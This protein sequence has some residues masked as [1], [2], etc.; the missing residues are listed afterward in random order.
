MK[1]ITGMRRVGKSSILQS[2]LH[3][4]V[5]WGWYREDQIWNMNK[6][7]PEFFHIRTGDDLW[8]ILEPWIISQWGRY[9]IA[10]DEVQEI[11]WWEQVLSG[12]LAQY[13]DRCDILITGSN[14]HLLSGELATLIAG[15]Y[16]TF[17]IYPLTWSEYCIFAGQSQ[18][19]ESF[20]DYMEF[21]GLP[22][23]HAFWKD[24]QLIISYLRSVYESI[25][26][27]DIVER[28]QIR[29]FDFL[30][31]LYYYTAGN[32]GNIVSAQSIARYLRNQRLTTSIDSI[33]QYLSYGLHT[34][35]FEK[36]GSVDPNTKKIFEIYNKYYFGDTWLR[37]AIVW[38]NP[39][40]DKGSLL[41]NII[42]MQ[43]CTYGYTV[44]IGRIGDWEIDFIAIK[45]EKKYYFQVAQSLISPE[46]REREIRSLE[47]ITDHHPKY[48]IHFDEENWGTT[49]SGIIL[50]SILDFEEQLRTFE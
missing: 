18:N 42:Y 40:R 10:I 30:K 23:I 17:R 12:I 24:K 5:L 38:Y 33:I 35:I 19:R 49:P 37:N 7:F 13:G 11:N 15:R 3:K 44:Q 2:V 20:F 32:I 50:L 6:E 25:V 21:G 9:I 26:L 43:L 36:V 27:R 46:T 1:V 28:F 39:S 14:S 45:W 4:L 31:N 22:G 41:E 8:R 16:I 34:Y 47:G 29:N 48:I